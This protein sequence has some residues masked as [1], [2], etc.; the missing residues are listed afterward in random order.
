MNW[1]KKCKL[2]AIEA[3]QFNRQ[4]YRNRWPLEGTS[5]DIQFSPKLTNKSWSLRWNSIKTYINI[6]V[7]L[8]WGI[9]KHGPQV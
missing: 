5:L 8:Q 6:D 4:S 2:L 9:Q 1:V 3:L 7:F